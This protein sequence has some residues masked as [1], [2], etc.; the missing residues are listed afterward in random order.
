VETDIQRIA[1][2]AEQQH[3]DTAA[4]AHY[5]HI[6]WDR[7][8]R[9]DADLD[10]IVDAIAAEVRAQI[11]CTA[12]AN[13]CRSI[14]VG[15]TYHDIPRLARGVDQPPAAINMLYVDFEAARQR[16]EWGVFRHSPCA[17][18][19]GTLCT[20]YPHR[21]AACRDYPAFTPDFRWQLEPIL[22]GMGVCP[23]IFHVIQRLKQRLGWLSS[24]PPAAPR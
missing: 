4:F 20:V 10:A 6:V 8:N 22:S 21:P 18:L 19:D 23:I 15:L 9:P 3:D 17:F 1:A 2:L 14:P 7:E 13:C 5:I 16:G 11:D 12:C 24:T